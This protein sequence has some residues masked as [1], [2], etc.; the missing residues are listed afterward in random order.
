ML[1][2]LRTHRGDAGLCYE[3][4]KLLMGLLM[5]VRLGLARL[6]VPPRLHAVVLH[7]PLY[8]KI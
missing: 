7:E 2:A 1:A 6:R 5:G 4:S 8:P 3:A